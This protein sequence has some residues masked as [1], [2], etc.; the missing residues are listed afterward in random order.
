MNNISQKTPDY[1]ETA[2]FNLW[3]KYF[4]DRSN[5][6][7]YLNATQSAL[8]AYS[9]TSYS[10]AGVIGHKNIKKYNNLCVVTLDMEGYG[11][12]ELM[13]IGLAKVIKGSYQDWDKFMERLRYFEPEKSLNATQN[14]YDFSNL[15][16]EILKSRIE[17]GLSY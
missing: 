1:R 3:V 17:R 16:S 4:T 12:G 6:E 9:S 5:K 15:G 2:K 13:K 14:N 10:L 11:L 7:T 8:K